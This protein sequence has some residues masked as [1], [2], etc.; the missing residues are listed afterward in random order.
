MCSLTAAVVAVAAAAT[1]AAV[2][3]A[4]TAAAAEAAVTNA[5]V[6]VYNKCKWRC[7]VSRRLARGTRDD[8][9]EWIGG[10]GSCGR[11]Q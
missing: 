2:A 6:T 4:A 8:E 7:V 3:A 1:A 11:S 5:I 9:E 10:G